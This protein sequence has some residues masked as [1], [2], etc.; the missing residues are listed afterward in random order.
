MK[1]LLTVL[2]GACLSLLVAGAAPA[3]RP[4]ILFI[5][6]DDHAQHAISAY[7]SN[8]NQTPHLDRLA[9]GGIRFNH[10]FVTNS[11]CTPSR[12][13]VLTGKYSHANG[14]PVFN[15]FNGGQPTVAKMLQAAGYHTGIIGKW[16][17]GS[18]PTGF[19]R[20]VI[21]PGQGVYNDPD[22]ITP[23][24]RITVKGHTT[25]VTTELGLEFL[26]TR[27]KDKPFFLMLHHKAPHR[28]WEPD[29]KN[30]ALFKDR[31]IPEPATLWDDYSTRPAA[32]PENR[33]TVANDLTRR[34]LKLE[35]P[36]DLPPG[37]QRQQWLGVKPTELEITGPDGTRRTL[38]GKELVQWKYQH[39][40]R[41]Y[42]ACVQGVDDSVGEV[43]DYLDRN[44]LA[45]NT[46]VI[47][48]SDNG[49]YLGDLGM[50]DKRFMYEPG[51]HIPL[52]VRGPGIKSG[53]VTDL[54]A[55]NADFAPTFLELAGAKI[56]A[57][58]H[59][60]SLVP[61]LKG[62]KPA[63]WRTSAY[64]RYYHDPGHHNTRAHYGVRTAT[65]KLIHYWKKDAWELFDLVRDPT[66]QKNIVA[67]PAQAGKV[68]E[69]KAEILRLQKQLGDTG[70]FADSI[71]RDGVDAPVDIPRLGG[72]SVKEAVAAATP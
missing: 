21:L 58:M 3:S 64:Y 10:A 30:K 45:E 32:L 25:A 18:M 68:A 22:F 46:I 12:A 60:R 48:S 17:L 14:V 36:A 57:D 31:V 71:P 72:K 27:P 4:N 7:G 59:G 34:D 51:L 53:S 44:G 16:H 70:Q 29:A 23:Q 67:D 56:P 40:M 66:E 1:S 54:F 28:A 62:G 24:G 13:V 19:D 8:V 37:P 5:F 52:I 2:L 11:I 15:V 65:H 35:P 38:T 49:W 6:S 42:L 9:K 69:L 47:Y 20:W 61:L 26:N 41:D 39:Y 55:L 63:G 50:Y 43:L 33:Q